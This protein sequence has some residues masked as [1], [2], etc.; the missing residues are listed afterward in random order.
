MPKKNKAN[1]NNNNGSLKKLSKK[2]NIT[3]KENVTNNE[4]N[5]ELKEKELVKNGVSNKSKSDKSKKNKKEDIKKIDNDDDSNDLEGFS[6]DEI[7]IE[8]FYDMDLSYEDEDEEVIN[9]NEEYLVSE[10]DLILCPNCGEIIEIEQLKRLEEC[11]SC[12]LPITEFENFEEY[13]TIYKSSE[14]EDEW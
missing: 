3:N 13:S 1:E 7:D 11:P 4:N 9:E 14:E 8:D 5:N 10:D 12:G 2:E 6:L